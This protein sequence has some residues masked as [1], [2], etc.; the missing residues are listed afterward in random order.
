M[1][2]VL[3]ISAVRFVDP[4]DLTRSIGYGQVRRVLRPVTL[5][6]CPMVIA[7]GTDRC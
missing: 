1:I 2:D 7:T 4:V 3:V 6:T 5:S